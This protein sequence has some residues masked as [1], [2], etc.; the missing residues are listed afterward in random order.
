[1]LMSNQPVNFR[2]VVASLVTSLCY[3][4]NKPQVIPFRPVR[5]LLARGRRLPCPVIRDNLMLGHRVPTGPV[6]ILGLDPRIARSPFRPT[7]E[8]FFGGAC[9]AR[10]PVEGGLRRLPLC[11][12][13]MTRQ[14][15]AGVQVCIA[16]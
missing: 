15:Q 7:F 1:M 10:A 8:P 16:A 4:T 12:D 5:G 13:E 11:H 6:V 9:R 3:R 2:T 14:H